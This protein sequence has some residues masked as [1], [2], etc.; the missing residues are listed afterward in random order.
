MVEIFLVCLVFFQSS[1]FVLSCALV[2]VCLCRGNKNKQK[3]IFARCARTSR[4]PHA[5]KLGGNGKREKHGTFLNRVILEIVPRNVT[6]RA[7]VT[8]RGM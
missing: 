1:L 4:D 5:M 7:I 8:D 3:K 6:R 2:V